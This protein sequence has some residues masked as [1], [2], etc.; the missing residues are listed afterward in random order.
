MVNSNQ[1]LRLNGKSWYYTSYNISNCY[2]W[3]F[4]F[5]SVVLKRSHSCRTTKQPGRVANQ[6]KINS[7]LINLKSFNGYFYSM[8]LKAGKNF[9]YLF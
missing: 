7:F 4:L 3:G 8:V 9:M 1:A 2:C 5:E 6:I